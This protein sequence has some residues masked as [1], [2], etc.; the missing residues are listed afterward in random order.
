MWTSSTRSVWNS[1]VGWSTQAQS[2]LEVRKIFS[3][4]KLNIEELRLIRLNHRT[5]TIRIWYAVGRYIRYSTIQPTT[6]FIIAYQTSTDIF[7]RVDHH[8]ICPV[9]RQEL[10][11]ALESII[12]LCRSAWIFKALGRGLVSALL[13]PVCLSSRPA[14]VSWTS[15]Q[16]SF[17]LHQIQIG[18]VLIVAAK[19]KKKEGLQINMHTPSALVKISTLALGR[20]PPFFPQ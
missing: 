1:L 2:S 5:R 14:Y 17:T 3:T 13:K 18:T 6:H 15:D 12:C 10:R 8:T 16:E 4:F 7:L 9:V 20:P 19:K 11:S